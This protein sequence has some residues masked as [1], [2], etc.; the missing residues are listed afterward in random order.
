ME[1]ADERPPNTQ[2]VLDILNEAG[3]SR[4]RT[5]HQVHLACASGY[6]RLVVKSYI[7][8]LLSC[9]AGSV[10]YKGIEGAV[11]QQE[12]IDQFFSIFSSCKIQYLTADRR[13]IGEAW[14]DILSTVVQNSVFGLRKIRNGEYSGLPRIAC[15]SARCSRDIESPPSR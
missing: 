6:S 9:G 13:F 1:K 15:S 14:L 8:V 11:V 5:P 12:M 3:L 7:A 2:E 10:R 4:K